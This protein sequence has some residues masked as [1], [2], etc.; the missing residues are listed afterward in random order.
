MENDFCRVSSRWHGDQRV[1][2]RDPNAIA[3]Q[4]AARFFFSNICQKMRGS[5][6]KLGNGEHLSLQA[7]KYKEND[8][9]VIII[10]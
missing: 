8:V 5:S 7:Y 9:Y 1:V 3:A 4:H 6:G 10:M 2:H